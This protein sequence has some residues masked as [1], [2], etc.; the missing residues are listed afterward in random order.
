M[1]RLDVCHLQRILSAPLAFKT[2]F[3]IRD[4]AVTSFD[5]RRIKLSNSPFHYSAP[6]HEVEVDV[7]SSELEHLDP[8]NIVFVLN[9]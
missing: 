7:A 4:V 2:R 3:T 5:T 8:G 9:N 6:G 1:T